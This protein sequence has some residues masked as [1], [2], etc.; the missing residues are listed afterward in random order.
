M[1]AGG[2][3]HDDEYLMWQYT[4]VHHVPDILGLYRPKYAGRRVMVVGAGH[5]AA[6]SIVLLEQLAR[7]EP[8]TSIGG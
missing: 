2:L 6:T 5:S 8:G 7:E 1:F 3:E 4:L